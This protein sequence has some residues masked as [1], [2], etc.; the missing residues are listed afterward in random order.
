MKSHRIESI[1]ILRGIVMVIMALDHV[2]TY[3]HYGNMY[4]HPTDLETTTPAIFFTRWITHFCAPVFV[5]LAGTSAFLSSTRKESKTEVAKFLLTR[6]LWLIFL[7][8]TVI[9][10]AWTFDPSFSITIFQVIWAIGI[11]M[12]ILSVLIFLPKNFLAAVGILLVVG[13]NLLDDFTLSGSGLVDII[14]YV[15]HQQ[16]IL[17]TDNNHVMFLYYP[18]MPWAG[19]MILGYLFGALYHNDY[20]AEKRRKWLL[21]IGLISTL[22]FVVIRL[23]NVYG[24]PSAWGEQENSLFTFMSFLNTTKYPP[25]LLFILMTIGPSIIVLL[26]LENIKNLLTDMLVIIGRVPL[27]FYVVH[28]YLIHL[29][30]MIAINFTGRSWTDWIWNAE[31][32]LESSTIDYG[33]SLWVVYL[34]WAVVMVVL[35][36]VCKKYHLYKGANKDKW[37]LSYL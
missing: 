20:S 33:F 25:S 27:F 16:N 7:E 13:H 9:N 23:Q 31:A 34:V 26:L 10:F 3:F 8:L 11:S 19:L 30:T 29:L 28:I 5:F 17:V 18:A 36:P 21:Q 15:F 4:A 2:R 32:F 24:D 12:V 35:F 14:W 22:L 6:G 37:W 1:D